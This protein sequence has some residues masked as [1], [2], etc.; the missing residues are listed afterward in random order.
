MEL[1]AEAPL[2]PVLAPAPRAWP[3]QGLQHSGPTPAANAPSLPAGGSSGP[4]LR[5][6]ERRGRDAAGPCNVP[7]C[8]AVLLEPS[9]AALAGNDGLDTCRYSWRLRACKA[10]RRAALVQWP[11]KGVM[12]W[13]QVRVPWAGAK[14]FSRF[15]TGS[16]QHPSP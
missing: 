5:W 14:L 16:S 11:G 4:H 9:V 1:D 8:T 13:C 12:R 15:C 7:G 3:A 10:H 6:L 2:L